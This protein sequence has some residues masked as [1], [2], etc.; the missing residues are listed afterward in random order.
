M[1]HERRQGRLRA[2]DVPEKPARHRDLPANRS[3]QYVNDPFAV[4]EEKVTEA[5]GY[6][7]A[8]ERQLR[9]LATGFD[10]G[11]RGK[12]AWSRDSAHER[13]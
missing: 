7:Q 11:L 3:P 9:L 6:R 2:T 13:G 8:M 5:T 1:A 12:V 10:L 4:E